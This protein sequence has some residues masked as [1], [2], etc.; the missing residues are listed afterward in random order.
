MNKLLTNIISQTSLTGFKADLLISLVLAVTTMLAAII[1]GML[2]Q[3]LNNFLMRK[4][5]KAA[6]VLN[7]VMFLGTMHHELSHALFAIL[8]GAK[9]LKIKCFTLFDKERLGYVNFA[10]S[11]G[12]LKQALQGSFIACA[13]VLTGFLTVPLFAN[14]A[15]MSIAQQISPVW[16]P[17]CLYI[18]ISILC[19]MR[20]SRAD[21]KIYLKGSL[22]TLPL[23]TLMILCGRFLMGLR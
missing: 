11:G 16:A 10:Y 2:I 14:L 12:K 17:I 13:P 9:V 21:L 20:M 3:N 22:V 8:T 23:L 1:V 15:I 18:A 5:S 6:F 4:S 7:R 19:H